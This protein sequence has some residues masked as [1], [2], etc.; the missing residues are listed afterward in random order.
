[1]KPVLRLLLLTLAAFL[2]SLFASPDAQAVSWK[3]A[4]DDEVRQH[5]DGTL[6]AWPK[7]EEHWVPVGKCAEQI[8]SGTVENAGENGPSAREQCRING[9]LNYDTTSEYTVAARTPVVRTNAELVQEVGNRAMRQSFEG[10]ARVQGTLR[11]SYADRLLTRYQ[12]MYGDR[13]L[14]T[15]VR[16]MGGVPGQGGRGSIRLDVVDGP[17]R[18]PN[19]IYDFKFGAAGLTPSRIN[20][21][22][23][24]GSFADDVPILPIRPTT[25]P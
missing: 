17:L 6:E 15:E 1:M 10:S 16:Y 21:I 7:A 24:V 11:H 4:P 3:T 5:E 20:Q 8:F 25:I 9:W 22:R 2:G 14:S 23:R 13:G 12:R 19:A 18:N